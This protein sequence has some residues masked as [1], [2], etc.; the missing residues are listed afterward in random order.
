MIRSI[1]ETHDEMNGISSQNEQAK[2]DG[3]GS[4]ETL[5][6]RNLQ[7]EIS[8]DQATEIYDRAREIYYRARKL[9]RSRSASII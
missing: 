1:F 8:I 2:T 9:H 4:S 5:I 6:T 7:S 3:M